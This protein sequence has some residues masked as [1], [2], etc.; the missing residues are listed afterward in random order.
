LLETDAPYLGKEPSEVNGSA[1]LVASIKE[2]EVDEVSKATTRS[3]IA[4][5]GLRGLNGGD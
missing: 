2:L 4:L 1:Q 3:C 5:F